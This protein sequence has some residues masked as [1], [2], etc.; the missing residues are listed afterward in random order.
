MALLLAAVLVAPSARADKATAKRLTEQATLAYKLGHFQEALED[1]S[2]AYGQFSAPLL[3]F[4]IGQCYRELGN[5]ERAVFFLRGYLREIPR[6]KN[7]ALVEDLV[8]ECET[9]LAAQQAE[10][11]RRQEEDR[12]QRALKLAEALAEQQQAADQVRVEAP[13]VDRAGL[14]GQERSGKTKLAIGLGI[15]AVGVVAVGVGAYFSARTNSDSNTIDDIATRH[16]SWSASA[17]STY[18]DG[19]RSVIAADV[20]YIGGAALVVAGGVVAVLGWQQGA[21]AKKTLSVVGLGKS[22]S[23]PMTLAWSF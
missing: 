3:L 15:A 21:T 7:R 2:M 5:Y 17:E 12:E 11:K 9:K 1:F 6:A 23:G 19:P 4:N 18:R 20:L 13:V 22:A 16:L 10:L 14:Q 8:A